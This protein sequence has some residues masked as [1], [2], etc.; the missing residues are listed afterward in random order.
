MGNS[1]TG[2][3]NLSSAQAVMDAVA[4]FD[5]YFF[6]EPLHYTDFDGYTELCRTSPVPIAGGE[7]LTG[8][9]E[10]RMFV[11]RD[12]FDIGQ[13]D[14][15]F[16]DGMLQV[17]EVARLLQDRGR[18]VASHA[19]GAGGSLMQNIIHFG[20]AAPNTCILEEPPDYGALHAE[21]I[22]DSFRMETVT[23]FHRKLP[24]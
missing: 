19:W 14:A 7:T 1:P 22:G 6:E 10:W 4:P 13:P 16:T 24:A 23:C 8:T 20:F 18:H 3:W 9:A 21:V 17:L 11:E 15:S 2:V 12:C 5:V